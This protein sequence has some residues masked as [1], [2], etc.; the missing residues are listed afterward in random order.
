[1]ILYW[2]I[3]PREYSERMAVL[4]H[5]EV[6]A[7]L[8]VLLIDGVEGT[9]HVVGTLT[10]T[11]TG[12]EVVIPYVPGAAEFAGAEGWFDQKSPPRNLTA[13][14]V[15]VRMALFGCSFHGVSQ[16]FGSVSASEGRVS[17]EEALMR[18]FDGN[19]DD[20][21]L[22]EEVQSEIDG[23]SK[24]SRL[25]SVTMTPESTGEGR[26]LRNVF[27]YRVEGVDGLI[28]KQGEA[29]LEI[30]T[31]PHG[32][33][34]E[35]VQITDRVVLTSKFKTSRPFE[36]HLAEQ[37]KFVAFLSMMFGCPIS[38]RK[39]EVRDGN[40]TLRTMDG[41]ARHFPFTELISRQT[42]G[43]YSKIQPSK[44]EL[45]FPIIRMPALTAETLTK[46]AENYDGWSRFLLPMVGLFRLRDNF[47]ENRAISAAMSLEAYGKGIASPVM[48]EEVSYYRERPTL[49]SYVFRALT[50]LALPWSQV[51]VS[52]MG[53]AR[54]IAKNYNGIK[55][56]QDEFP[57]SLETKILSD[58]SVGIVRILALKLVTSPEE[59]ARAD[60]TQQFRQAFE[61]ARAN[62]FEIDNDGKAVGQETE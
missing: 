51:A 4:S 46:W 52:E 45:A 30:S 48:D 55:H 32:T 16:S 38:F 37:W 33:S 6:A 40:V 7:V 29:T 27:T 49:A 44:E 15:D 10:L 2:L 13:A 19:S 9:P 24:W 12:V 54:A 18:D 1:M 34:G 20:P 56:P 11:E 60:T 62:K 5:L 53:L 41:V 39:H 21:L 57:N 50:A 35:G 14:S 59:F 47:I 36:D 43:D 42:V 25:N 17:V 58:I 8:P 22:I 23:L 3:E 26:T 28:W 31:S 61:L